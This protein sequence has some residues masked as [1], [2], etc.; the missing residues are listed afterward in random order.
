MRDEAKTAPRRHA[1]LAAAIVLL[2]VGLAAKPIM[3]TLPA[4]WLLHSALLPVKG[5]EEAPAWRRAW[6]RVPAAAP[7]LAL[8]AAAAIHVIGGTAGSTNTGFDIP[9]LPVDRYAATQLRV[10]PT[11]L[12]LLA[13]PA[14]QCGDRWFRTSGGFF[15]P[16]VLL[17]AALLGAVGA[18]AA[19]AAV[20]FRGASGDC[21]GAARAAG[22][23]ALFFLVALAPSSSAVPL[24]D[25]Y[26]EHR[27]YLASLGVF[28]GAAAG[29][30]LLVRR[31][32]GSRAAAAGAA[33]TLIV[34]AAAGIATARR[35]AVWNTSL[36]FWSDAAS[37]ARP[38]ARAVLALARD[39]S[40]Q[41]RVGDALANLSRARELASDGSLDDKGLLENTVSLLLA[42][43]RPAEARAE[44]DR[45]LATSPQAPDA[46]AELAHVEFVASRGA[47]PEAERA[48]L[49][50]L[51]LEPANPTALQI[52]ARMRLRR[53]DVAGARE[54]LR[55]AAATHVV[56]PSIYW[57]LGRI[58][59]RSGDL[60][61]A[62]AAYARA[63]AQP[64][65]SVV[66]ARARDARARL[67][68]P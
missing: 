52:L 56:D 15:E 31:L 67:G 12:K 37:A 36:A 14:G 7:L 45:V 24:L 20:R 59:E 61:A 5:E 9:G 64:M 27:V 30:A 68:C 21:P 40:D 63:A 48:A 49:A 41:R 34:V 38:K 35:T 46:L 18:G 33:V 23:G 65:S 58:E 11:Y 55:A 42:L 62:C 3:A 57:E 28:L 10:I 22:F 13:W 51:A 26:A 66:S 8:S 43:G 25:P 29:A 16:S 17:G 54:A 2:A 60:D 19:L 6:R 53:G 50:A 44:V 4:A 1:L 39:L 32:A 47:S